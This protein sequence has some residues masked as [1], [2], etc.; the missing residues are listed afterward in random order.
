M[1]LTV[2]T[3]LSKYDRLPSHETYSRIYIDPS[4]NQLK[5]SKFP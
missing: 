1:S 4:I 5:L 2:E 3:P